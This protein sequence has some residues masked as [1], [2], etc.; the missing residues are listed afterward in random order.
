MNIDMMCNLYPLNLDRMLVTFFV[1]DELWSSSFYQIPLKKNLDI[2]PFNYFMYK[3][4]TSTDVLFIFI[5]IQGLNITWSSCL[6]VLVPFSLGNILNDGD[7]G[8]IYFTSGVICIVQSIIWIGICICNIY[9][10][11][12]Y[13]ALQI[14]FYSC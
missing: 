8:F 14:S 3:L 9:T 2:I 4:Y 1:N 5:F 11:F 13:V 12:L 7:M 10:R 6:Q